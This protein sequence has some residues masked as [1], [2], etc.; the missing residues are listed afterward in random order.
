VNE[1]WILEVIFE[2]LKGHLTTDLKAEKGVVKRSKPYWASK[3]TRTTPWQPREIT[4]ANMMGYKGLLDDPAISMWDMSMV[5][6]LKRPNESTVSKQGASVHRD[7]AELSGMFGVSA[8]T[9][10]TI[11]TEAGHSRE[12][13]SDAGFRAPGVPEAM[14]LDTTAVSLA[15]KVGISVDVKNIS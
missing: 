5:S 9:H 14:Q 4:Y 6:I 3:V 8:H 10:L 13:T 2:Y 15:D 12:A 1:Q 7:S 11:L